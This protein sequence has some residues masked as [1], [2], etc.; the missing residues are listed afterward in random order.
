MKNPVKFF[1]SYAHLDRLTAGPLL[2]KLTTQ[3]GAARDY[4][5]QLWRDTAILPG[6]E[7]HDEIQEA[8]AGCDVGLLLV[9]PAFLASEYIR[10]HELPRLLAEKPVIP[11]VLCEVSKFH[12]LQ[13]LEQKQLFR[14]TTARG[15]KR[16]FADC[17]GTQRDEFVRRL[18]EGIVGRL[19][20]LQ[21]ATP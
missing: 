5:F 12:A 8:L 16:A 3:M 4:E 18:F 9:S 6:E 11:A 21:G 7:W 2:G 17:Q 1:V 10:R 14:L 20:K 19:R 15:Q 13:G